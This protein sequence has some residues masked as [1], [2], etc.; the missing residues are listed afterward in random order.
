MNECERVLCQ[1]AKLTM[2]MPCS[3]SRAW[4]QKPNPIAMIAAQKQ[5]LSEM[6]PMH[7]S[8]LTLS[9]SHAVTEPHWH[10]V[11]VHWHALT[12]PRSHLPLSFNH[13]LVHCHS[14][15]PSCQAVF[16]SRFHDTLP[17]SHHLVHLH[18]V[19][20]LTQSR[21]HVTPPLSHQF[22]TLSH[23]LVHL[24]RE[25]HIQTT[26]NGSVATAAEVYRV[27]FV[28]MQGRCAPRP[29]SRSV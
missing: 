20:F 6:Q 27:R 10:A 22:M 24:H 25:A 5:S 18:S 12:L 16:R 8:I 21:F 1:S 9:L 14:G 2:M 4:L 28:S 11:V 17:L 19:I 23:Y 7:A 26:N 15:I 29:G 13:T 3:L